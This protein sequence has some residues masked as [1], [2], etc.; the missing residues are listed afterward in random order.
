MPT[1]LHATLMCGSCGRATL[2]LF[3][4]RRAQRKGPGPASRGPQFLDLV[5][6]CEICETW[7]TAAARSRPDRAR[8][9]PT[10]SPT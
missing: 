1:T 2:H 7:S 9:R 10:C 8:A 4:E 6:A 5:Y 3:H